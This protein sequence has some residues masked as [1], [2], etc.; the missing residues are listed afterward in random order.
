M[1]LVYYNS[2]ILN[3]FLT[4]FTSL[5]FIY[6]VIKFNLVLGHLSEK[7]KRSC[8]CQERH[9]KDMLTLTCWRTKYG[10]TVQR[11][12]VSRF[13]TYCTYMFFYDL[14]ILK[15][16]I[17]MW[18]KIS[19]EIGSLKCVEY[20]EKKTNFPILTSLKSQIFFINRGSQHSTLFPKSFWPAL[21]SYW[22]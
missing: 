15:I 14:H 19:F 8:T 4:F 13:A 7:I 18:M 22:P 10:E 1:S 9:A 5:T 16:L 3:V 17:V 20:I 12:F 11:I 21:W 6:V 2:Y